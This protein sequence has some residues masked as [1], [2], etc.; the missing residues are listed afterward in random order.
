[1]SISDSIAHAIITK[2]NVSFNY[3]DHLRLCSPHALGQKGGKT[4][5]LV[6]QYGGMTS[7]GAVTGDS[8]NNWRCMDVSLISDFQVIRGAWHS[9]DNQYTPS[10]CIDTMLAEVAY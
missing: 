3:Q 8:P 4:N 5:V 2:Q 9:S 10:K 6:Y 7:K 1:M